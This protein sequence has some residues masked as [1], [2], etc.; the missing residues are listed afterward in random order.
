MKEHKR[1][2]GHVRVLERVIATGTRVVHCRAPRRARTLSCSASDGERVRLVLRVARL[3][4]VPDLRHEPADH[5]AVAWIGSR[6]SEIAGHVAA[7]EV[8]N[9]AAVANTANI[10]TTAVTAAT[11]ATTAS[12][13]AAAAAAAARRCMRRAEPRSERRREA[14]VDRLPLG[15]P[16]GRARQRRVR[17]RPHQ[18]H[19]ATQDARVGGRAAVGLGER[20]CYCVA[21]KVC[22]LRAR[23]HL[24]HE[25]GTRQTLA[26]HARTADEIERG[27]MR[28]DRQ[29][30]GHLAGRV[31]EHVVAAAHVQEHRSHDDASAVAANVAY[32]SD[33]AACDA[34]RPVPADAPT[35]FTER[36]T[37]PQPCKMSC[38]S[39]ER[40]PPGTVVR[41]FAESKGTRF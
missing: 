36:M 25:H 21:L 13:T 7:R 11:A 6:V 35:C 29:R 17:R 4:V 26:D 23:A 19:V 3:C 12:A 28:F 41:P 40:A 24:K 30:I 20:A 15:H 10:S 2:R 31:R 38:P 18:Q 37:L 32:S 9:T 1:H 22:A 33:A 39:R 34:P 27:E 5:A 16:L 14:R 8:V